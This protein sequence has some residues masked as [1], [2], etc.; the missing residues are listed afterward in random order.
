MTPFSS[1]ACRCI[2]ATAGRLQVGDPMSA[3][4]TNDKAFTANLYLDGR[5]VVLNQQRLQLV[6]RDLRITQR[7]KLDAEVGLCDL[8]LASFITLADHEDDVALLLKFVPQG[9]HY[10]IS[11]VLP[12]TFDG[13]RLYIEESSKYLLAS[14]SAPVQNFSISTSGV[15]KASFNNFK[16]GPVYLGL[17]SQPKN[18]ALYRYVSEGLN[19]FVDVDPNRTGHNAFNNRPA[20]FVIKVVN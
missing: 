19:T 4:K 14:T 9:D 1:I 15:A 3:A 5:P 16:S 2:R 13:A 6:L 8:R 11:L 18:R 20:L 12:G 17:S 10:A 7:E